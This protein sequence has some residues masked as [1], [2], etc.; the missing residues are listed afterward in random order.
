MH[1][2]HYSTLLLPSPYDYDVI[3]VEKRNCAYELCCVSIPE[4]VDGVNIR[5]SEVLSS[6]SGF[7]NIIKNQVVNPAQMDKWEN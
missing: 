6:V 2:S 7:R 3:K 5:A 4:G 1:I